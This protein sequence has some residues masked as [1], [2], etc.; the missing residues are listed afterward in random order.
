MPPEVSTWVPRR[1]LKLDTY[2][3]CLIFLKNHS[4][5]I[6]SK[7]LQFHMSVNGTITYSILNYK[8]KITLHSLFFLHLNEANPSVK[9]VNPE[10]SSHHL[11]LG[12]M[13]LTPAWNSFILI[14]KKQHMQIFTN[15]R[16]SCHFPAVPSSLSMKWNS[17]SLGIWKSFFT[18]GT[19]STSQEGENN[20]LNYFE[21]NNFCSTKR[22]EKETHRVREG[23]CKT[24]IW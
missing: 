18:Q 24:Y 15:I 8:L 22:C 21:V 4:L 14:S 5:Y 19:E 1:H 7:C 11:S 10:P 12:L 13:Q 9:P 6:I 17:T 23:I 2:K 20:K 3:M 16:W